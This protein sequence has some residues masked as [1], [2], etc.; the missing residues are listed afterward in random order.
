MNDAYKSWNEALARRYFAKENRGRP[1]YLCVDDDELEELVP[2]GTPPGV[3]SLVQAVRLTLGTG[4]T[5]FASHLVE[6]DK[7]RQREDGYPPY[8]GL[9]GLCVLAASRMARDSARGIE[10]NAYYPQLNLLLGRP[11]FD[12]MPSGFERVAALW[13]DLCRWLDACDGKYG[14]S[15]A[16]QH[17]HF[18]NVGWPMSQCLLR[19]AD[20]RRLTEFFRAAG[21]EPHEEVEARQLWVLLKN[22]AWS[23][24]GLSQSAASVIT[25]ATGGIE[26]QLAE[27]VK[28]EYDAWEGELLDRHGRRRGLIAVTLAIAAGGRRVRLGIAPRRP[29]GL[30]A[31]ATV[32]NGAASTIEINAVSDEWYAPLDMPVTKELL[33]KGLSLEAASFSLSYDPADVVP[34]RASLGA[35]A[36]VSVRQA[37]LF[38][39]HCVLAAAPRLH[40][41]RQF[42]TAHAE[43]GWQELETNALPQGWA[44]IRGVRFTRPAAQAPL[45]L[46]RLAP[47]LHTATRIAGGLQLGPQLFLTGGEPDVWISVE[48]GQA[49][50]VELDGEALTANGTLELRLSRLT[51]PLGDG[52]HELVA[53]GI[54]RHFATVTGFPVV[55]PSGA[56]T[57][58]HIFEHHAAYKPKTVDAAPLAKRA[59]PRGTVYVCGASVIGDEADLPKAPIEPTLIPEGLADYVVLGASP[60]ELLSPIPP[61][62]PRWIR[63]LVDAPSQ[64]FDL[65]LP[66]DAQWVIARALAGYQVR[67]LASC[68]KPATLEGADSSEAIPG[69]W[70]T[71]ILRAA[72]DGARPLRYRETWDTYVEAATALREGGNV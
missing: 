14:T 13:R 10:A 49:A 36:W 42:L 43:S 7:W 25:H 40:Q 1:V 60:N 19:E 46:T 67:P 53:G 70:C 45:E 27:I 38:E 6:R 64:F 3:E 62:R 12:G 71:A 41:V 26:E 23:G 33:E 11:A 17:P 37:T 68:P 20:R 35:A 69:E 31:T 65:P 28:H 18:V 9:L 72:E 57:Y 30:P 29:E 59:P 52:Q 5:R 48:D 44:A 55:T 8:I 21:L 24:C 61:E 58:G 2:N 16:R 63:S 66:F 34:L 4:E 32:R 15:T 22:W 39:D 56:A 54:R 51:P 47:R 50:A